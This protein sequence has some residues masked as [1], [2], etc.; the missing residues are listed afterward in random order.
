MPEDSLGSLLATCAGKRLATG[1]GLTW[2]PVGGGGP[3]HLDAAHRGASGRCCL[4]LLRLSD[5]GSRGPTQP[6]EESFA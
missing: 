5:C 6:D 4:L 2:L 3:P 1:G